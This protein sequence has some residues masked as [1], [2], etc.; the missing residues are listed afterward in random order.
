MSV[1]NG[2]RANRNVV[3]FDEPEPPVQIQYI[4]NRAGTMVI[5]YRTTIQH[6]GL[7]EFR[8]LSS[9]FQGDLLRK[10][11]AQRARWRAKWQAVNAREQKAQ[12]K[13]QEAQM[14]EE[15]REAAEDQTE[16]ARQAQKEIEDLLI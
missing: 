10:V 3:A 2:E 7:G 13:E 1:A 14:L 11:E 4:H 9:S 16:E 15:N 12:Q 6:K 5:R 8:E